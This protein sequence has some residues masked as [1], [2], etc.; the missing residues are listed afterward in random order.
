MMLIHNFSVNCAFLPSPS[1]RGV[2]GEGCAQ[3][4]C[5]YPFSAKRSNPHPNPLPEG[6]GAFS[7]T[8]Q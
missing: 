5:T 1:G 3:L 8:T 4:E 7:G 6:E 2:G